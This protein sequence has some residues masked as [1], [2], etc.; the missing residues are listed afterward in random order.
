METKHTPGTW[1]IG[2]DGVVTSTY[3][4]RNGQICTKDEAT[5]YTT[6]QVCKIECNLGSN[7]LND[8]QKTDAK[9]ILAAP[10]LLAAAL[11]I[12][13]EIDTEGLLQGSYEKLLAAIEKATK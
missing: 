11:Q 2:I 3:P 4:S 6:Q 12:K 8:R 1:K 7:V 9:L 10:D 13:N 5:H